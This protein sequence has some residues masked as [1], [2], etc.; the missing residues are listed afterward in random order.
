MRV[1]EGIVI[2]D[3]SALSKVADNY[4]REFIHA[5]GRTKSK[6]HLE[7]LKRQI[8]K[9]RSDEDIGLLIWSLGQIGAKPELLKLEK[10]IAKN[11][12]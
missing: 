7:L 2:N 1:V 4:P 10:E 3:F 9:L 6:K 8:L 12:A 5:I 11:S